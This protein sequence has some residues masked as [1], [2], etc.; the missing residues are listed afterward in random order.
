[1]PHSA[2]ARR[3]PASAGSTAMHSGARG[4]HDGLA[5]LIAPA[6]LVTGASPLG[7]FTATYC[8][9]AGAAPPDSGAGV[10]TS[11][12]GAGAAAPPGGAGGVLI[13][14]FAALRRSLISEAINSCC[15]SL[16]RLG[17]T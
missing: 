6:A 8:T 2:T 15:A 16:W 4:E 5:T 7:S 3:T 12:C 9:V 11:D 1:M 10:G 13:S 14:T 17:L